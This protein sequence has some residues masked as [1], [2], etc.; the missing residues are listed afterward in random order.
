MILE[1]RRGRWWV[2]LDPESEVETELVFG[3]CDKDRH[4]TN[5]ILGWLHENISGGW[6]TSTRIVHRKG[7]YRDFIAVTFSDYDDALMFLL[8]FEQQAPEVEVVEP[9]WKQWTPSAQADPTAMTF[10]P[11]ACR[12]RYFKGRSDETERPVAFCW[13]MSRNAAGNYLA[14]EVRTGA[15]VPGS[16]RA[17]DKRKDAKEWAWTKAKNFGK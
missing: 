1:K 8:T 14:W 15:I 7:D 12:S 11:W 9:D 3:L 17:F 13:S 10:E 6:R 4:S 2:Y 5:R 16:V